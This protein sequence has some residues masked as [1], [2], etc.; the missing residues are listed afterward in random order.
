MQYHSE[1]N[2]H[3]LPSRDR[4][5]W[6]V[7][8]QTGDADV[9]GVFRRFTELRRRLIPYLAA[10]GRRAVS[11]RRPLMRALL[12]D[13]HDDDRIWEFPYQYLLG[14]A[15]L[16][17]PVCEEGATAWR[18]YLPGG[19]WVDAWSGERLQ[20]RTVVERPVPLDEIPLF[21]T[22]ARAEELLP[23]VRPGELVEVS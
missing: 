16:V 4:T 18:T 23:L 19:E 20:G 7:A 8:E 1:F 22:A 15:L 10:E 11:E 3:R 5:P 12:F 13:A 21:I 9:V 17:S 14:D 2:H 6:N